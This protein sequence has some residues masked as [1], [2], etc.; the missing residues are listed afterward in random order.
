MKEIKVITRTCAPT[1]VQTLVQ[2]GNENCANYINNNGVK[3]LP[4]NC[5]L[6]SIF[7]DHLMDARNIF[8]EW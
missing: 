7:L 5:E 8:N 4:C 1:D 3:S 2:N 6:G